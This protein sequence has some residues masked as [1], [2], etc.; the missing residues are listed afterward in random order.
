MLIGIKP[1]KCN[2]TY[3]ND[4]GHNYTNNHYPNPD[5]VYVPEFACFG[6]NLKPCVKQRIQFRFHYLNVPFIQNCTLRNALVN[7]IRYLHGRFN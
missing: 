1:K 7:M 6:Y 5:I 3:A 2:A 4:Y